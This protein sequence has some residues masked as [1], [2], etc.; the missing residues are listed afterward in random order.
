MAENI[1][2]VLIRIDI[3]NP[4]SEDLPVTNTMYHVCLVKFLLS[5]TL[6][7]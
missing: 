4:H 5:K 2:M 7:S 6:P 3:F 1:K